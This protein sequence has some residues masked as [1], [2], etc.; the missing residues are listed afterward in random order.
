M[1][2]PELLPWNKAEAAAGEQQWCVPVCPCKLGVIPECHLTKSPCRWAQHRMRLKGMVDCIILLF[3]WCRYASGA[4]NGLTLR[5][6]SKRLEAEFAAVYTA[7]LMRTVRQQLHLMHMQPRSS[8]GSCK[9]RQEGM[10]VQCRA[11]PPCRNAAA[12]SSSVPSADCQNL[13][14]NNVMSKIVINYA[15]QQVDVAAAALALLYV[16]ARLLAP[17]WFEGFGLGPVMLP[18]AVTAGALAW[19]TAE[20][21]RFGFVTAL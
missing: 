4:Q 16:A 8:R 9:L 10:A 21:V 12:R 7:V 3:D 13:D 5:F 2:P 18:G 1:S 14:R 17:K 15:F 19:R 11:P 6:V 20:P